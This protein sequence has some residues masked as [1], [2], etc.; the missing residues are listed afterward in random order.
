MHCRKD[1]QKYAKYHG[2][3]H[4]R[5]RQFQGGREIPRQFAGHRHLG[6]DGNPHIPMGQT[7]HVQGI[8]GKNR[9]IQPQGLTGCL[10]NFRRCMGSHQH[11]GRIAGNDV[12]NTEGHNRYADE[13]ENQVDQSLQD[14][15]E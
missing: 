7:F 4:S 12:G 5:Q 9:L 1:A 6:A 3:D 14:E 11:A 15:F 13:D 2:D 8:L 10:Q